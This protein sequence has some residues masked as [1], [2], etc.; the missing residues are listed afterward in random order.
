VFPAWLVIGFSLLLAFRSAV[1]QAPSVR[2]DSTGAQL[3]IVFPALPL[4]ESGCRFVS[5]VPGMT[6]REY[7]W[8]VVGYF[9]DAGYPWNHM[10]ELRFEFFFP[11]QIELT[12]ARFDSIAAVTRIK[13]SELRG[14][15]PHGVLMPLNQASVHRGKAHLKLSVQSRPAVDA[16]L[17]MGKDSVAV[18]WCERN[19]WP[20]TIR[21]TRLER[22]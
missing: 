8:Q 22:Y 1:A 9:P 17:R 4:T 14:E 5:N 13:V 12:E 2:L 20:P 6:G 10:F 3:E 15:P 16:L 7:S 21:L 11:D 19:Q 18:F